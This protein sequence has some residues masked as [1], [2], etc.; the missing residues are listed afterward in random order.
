MVQGI[1]RTIFWHGAHD[2]D[3]VQSLSDMALA[4]KKC[5]NSSNVVLLGD[6]NV[7]ML[8]GS[9]GDPFADLPKRAQKHSDERLMLQQAMD[10]CKLE[11]VSFG[12]V[13]GCCPDASHPSCVDLPISRIP[14]GNQAGTP[15][16]LDH[17]AARRAGVKTS[18]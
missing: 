17:V 13:S 1:L 3:F 12:S 6:F 4:V 10:A 7:D 18:L 8:P 9:I 5:K 14:S 15:S 2:E 11:F 16:C